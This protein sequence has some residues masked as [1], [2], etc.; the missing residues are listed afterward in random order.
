MR[1]TLP[2]FLLSVLPVSAQSALVSVIRQPRA[3]AAE[4]TV[5]ITE[6]QVRDGKGRP[7]SSLPDEAWDQP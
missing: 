3:T 2:A 1:Q 5:P 4:F 7:Q 6:F